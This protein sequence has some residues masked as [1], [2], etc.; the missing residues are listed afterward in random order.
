MFVNYLCATFEI[1][2]PKRE[3]VL[4]VFILLIL[5]YRANDQAKLHGRKT[6]NPKDILEAMQIME[7]SDFL[8]RLKAELDSL[9]PCLN[10]YTPVTA[11]SSLSQSSTNWLPKSAQL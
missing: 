2:Q 8:P 3:T 10:F 6:I 9:Y 4:C 1:P 5:V 11:D 7:F